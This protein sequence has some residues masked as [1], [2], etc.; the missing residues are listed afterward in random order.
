[1]LSDGFGT[2]AV[3]CAKHEADN[4]KIDDASNTRTN[5]LKY[6]RRFTRYKR[7]RTGFF[8]LIRSCYFADV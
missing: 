2:G 3:D 6:E 8:R 7:T 5:G 1:M 4:A